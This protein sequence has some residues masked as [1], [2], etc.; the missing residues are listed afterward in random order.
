VFVVTLLLPLSNCCTLQRFTY[1]GPNPSMLLVQ[2]LL[3]LVLVLAITLLLPWLA[4]LP[5]LHLRCVCSSPSSP[6]AALHVPRPHPSMLLVQL[7]LLLV[8]V[9]V[10]TLLL[11]MLGCCALP[12]PV[13]WCNFVF[14]LLLRVPP[15]RFAYRGPNLAMP[16]VQLLLLL[17]PVPIVTL[18]LPLSNCCTL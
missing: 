17:A 11:L 4:C 8:L 1:L 13:L 10:V 15:Q 12:A 9:L 16:L 18:L 5:F 7:L 2:L 3:L 6:S 14:A